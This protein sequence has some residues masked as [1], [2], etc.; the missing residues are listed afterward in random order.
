MNQD[1]KPSRFGSIPV[2]LLPS[3]IKQLREDIEKSNASAWTAKSDDVQKY[4]KACKINPQLDPR[5]NQYISS[6]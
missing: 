6:K 2:E 4:F 5:Y 3:L 1:K